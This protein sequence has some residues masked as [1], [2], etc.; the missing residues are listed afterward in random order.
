MIIPKIIHR[1]PW[2]QS[3]RSI[4][5]HVPAQLRDCLAEMRESWDAAIQRQ[6]SKQEQHQSESLSDI[7]IVNIE[8]S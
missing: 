2:F 4:S 8:I 7:L 6:E 1:K 5:F 3:I